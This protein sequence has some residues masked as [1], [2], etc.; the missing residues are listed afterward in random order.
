MPNLD[1]LLADSLMGLAQDPDTPL[2]RL[3]DDYKTSLM[4]SG[5]GDMRTISRGGCTR[6]I[7]QCPR[8]LQ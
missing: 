2:I 4:A 1:Q 7:A 8:T 3:V 5:R 6:S